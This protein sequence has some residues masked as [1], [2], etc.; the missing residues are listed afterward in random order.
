MPVSS[1]STGSSITAAPTPS[2][3]MP[4]RMAVKPAGVAAGGPKAPRRGDSVKRS[5]QAS[6]VQGT[7]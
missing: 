1:Q 5:C 4:D 6:R 3:T 7:A 2:C